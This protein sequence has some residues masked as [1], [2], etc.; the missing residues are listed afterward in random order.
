[1]NFEN[2]PIIIEGVNHSGTRVLVDILSILGSEGGDYNN[3][4]KENKFFLQ[5]HRDLINKV[6][7]RGWTGTILNID[8]INSFN[9]NGEHKQ[10]IMERIKSELQYHYP[11]YKIKPWHW[12][13]PT[14]ALFEKTWTEIYPDAYYIYL[15]REPARV[16]QS[17]VRRNAALKFKDG[18]K[19][20]EIMESKMK[21]IPKRNELSICYENLESEIEKIASFIPIDVKPEQIERAKSFYKPRNRLWYFDRSIKLNFKNIKAHI[22]YTLYKIGYFTRNS[23]VK[24]ILTS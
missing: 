21:S 14:S 11:N 9:D 3:H 2:K 10:Y 18:L 23:A 5:L 7:D 12:K 19:F 8:F 17:F 16:A 4:W 20:Y 22:Y 6:S 24:G 13:C 15:S 1:M